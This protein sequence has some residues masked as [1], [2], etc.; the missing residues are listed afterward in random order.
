MRPVRSVSSELSSKKRS[1]RHFANKKRGG[2]E[3]MFEHSTQMASARHDTVSAHVYARGARI[4][5]LHSVPSQG[6]TS[7]AQTTPKAVFL[8]F[9]ICARHQR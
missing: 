5:Y 6:H 1:R 7:S 4:R 3:P 2:V 8:R 9:G